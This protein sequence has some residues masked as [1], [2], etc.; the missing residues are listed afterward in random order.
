MLNGAIFP[1]AMLIRYSNSVCLLTDP[2]C[3]GSDA[4]LHVP[5]ED[6]GERHCYPVQEKVP[7]ED[8]EI[9]RE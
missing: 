8:F 2:R 3:P 4:T 6:M 7:E 5:Q 9:I 1:P